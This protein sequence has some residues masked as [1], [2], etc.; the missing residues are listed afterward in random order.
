M[1]LTEDVQ[2]VVRR[3]VRLS[4]CLSMMLASQVSYETYSTIRYSGALND[5]HKDRFYTRHY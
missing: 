5:C 2:P 1:M 4:G 3:K